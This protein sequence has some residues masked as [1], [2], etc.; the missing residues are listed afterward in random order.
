MFV[1]EFLHYHKQNQMLL[2][3]TLIYKGGGVNSELS[4]KVL[5]SFLLVGSFFFLSIN[6][7]AETAKTNASTPNPKVISMSCEGHSKSFA[8]TP[9]NIITAAKL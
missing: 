2:L 5:D 9:I 7:I 3:N 1:I 4:F 8:I 6:L